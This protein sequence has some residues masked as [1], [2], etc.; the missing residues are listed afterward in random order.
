MCKFDPYAFLHKEKDTNVFLHPRPS[1]IFTS[2]L[3]AKFR[4]SAIGTAYSL[5]VIRSGHISRSEKTSAL[6][7]LSF[8][9][10]P[11]VRGTIPYPPSS[12][13]QRSAYK[14]SR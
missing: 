8:A 14:E 2:L 5:P 13:R 9:Y 12:Y 6:Q 1:L 11:A 4:P 10:R 7:R 3:P